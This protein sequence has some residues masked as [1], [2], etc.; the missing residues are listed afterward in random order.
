MPLLIIFIEL[1]LLYR[2][3][4]LTHSY[5]FY[6]FRKVFPKNIALWLYSIIF[7]PG[8]FIHETSHFVM[9]TILFVPTGEMKLIPEYQEKGIKL[10]ELAIAKTDPIRRFLIGISPIILGLTLILGFLYFASHNTH[11]LDMK[12]YLLLGYITFVIGNTMFSSKKDLEG[13]WKFF[14][15]IGSILIFLIFTKTI[16]TT[17]LTSLLELNS[18][19]LTETSKLLLIPITIDLVL[20]LFFKYTKLGGG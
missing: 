17:N 11:Y 20:I 13:A 18:N 19:I 15:V 14:L 8:T 9:A 1:L 6:L 4:I 16:N 3:S 5:L 2:F 7:V 10:G 12:I